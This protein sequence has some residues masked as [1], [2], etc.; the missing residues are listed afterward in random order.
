MPS[1]TSPPTSPYELVLMH[2]W[3]AALYHSVQHARQHIDAYQPQTP[4]GAALQGIY[5]DILALCDAAIRGAADTRL[6]EEIAAV[7]AM[8]RQALNRATR[9]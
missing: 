6:P 1:R 7:L 3:F 2:D 8:Q 9:H 5:H 4:E